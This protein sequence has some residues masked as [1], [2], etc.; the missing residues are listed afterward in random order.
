MCPLIPAAR[1]SPALE[2]AKPY[3]VTSSHIMSAMI[4]ERKPVV[5]C[6]VP[7]SPG[8]PGRWAMHWCAQ[9]MNSV[10]STCTWEALK[11]CCFS[12]AGAFVNHC[13]S[14]F[15]VGISAPPAVPESTPLRISF[16]RLKCPRFCMRSRARSAGLPTWR[17]SGMDTRKSVRAPTSCSKP[18]V[19]ASFIR[20]TRSC[21]SISRP[22]PRP[23]RAAPLLPTTAQ[24]PARFHAGASLAWAIEAM[25]ALVCEATSCLNSR[26]ADRTSSSDSELTPLR[27][28]GIR[29]TPPRGIDPPSGMDRP[30]P[31]TPRGP[32]PRATKQ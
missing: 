21:P 9:S 17:A 6:I 22:S 10:D 15:A 16:I 2:R 19:G 28:W 1:T 5:G 4:W 26:P 30:S 31:C 11:A 32:A 12:T 24:R 25:V 3:A 7:A 13:F 27:Y 8:R 23:V 14:C 20:K 29:R 18:A